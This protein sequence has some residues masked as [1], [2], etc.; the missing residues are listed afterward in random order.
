MKVEIDYILMNIIKWLSIRTAPKIYIYIYI[1]DILQNIIETFSK[2]RN[3]LVATA[4]R[5]YLCPKERMKRQ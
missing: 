3:N 2:F 1:L 4:G 5:L